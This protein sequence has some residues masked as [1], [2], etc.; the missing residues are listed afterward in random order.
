M[1][2][3]ILLKSIEP[4]T[5]DTY[6]L[7]CERPDGYDF[8]PGQ[9]TDLALDREGWRDQTRPFTFTSQ[10]EDP[11]LEFVI[12]TYPAHHGVTSEVATLIPGEKLLIGLPWGAIHDSGPGVFI[13]GGAGVTPF[14]PI[15]RRR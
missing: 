6:R 7:E 9:A 8:R 4:V 2:R 15:L 10:P 3:P 13:A 11:R 14:I 12:K 1:P 5:H